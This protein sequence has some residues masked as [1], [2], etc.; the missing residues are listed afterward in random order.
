MEKEERVIKGPVVGARKTADAII[1]G[2]IIALEGSLLV[3]ETW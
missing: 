2:T 1:G 3:G